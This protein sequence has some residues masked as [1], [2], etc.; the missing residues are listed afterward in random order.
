MRGPT[1]LEF[2]SRPPHLLGDE[3]LLCHRLQGNLACGSWP[4]A[5]FPWS[6]ASS[7]EWFSLTEMNFNP[8]GC[9]FKPM[10]WDFGCVGI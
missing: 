3:H 1:G 7:A 4:T 9:A 5:S 8:D 6:K 10:D 2:S